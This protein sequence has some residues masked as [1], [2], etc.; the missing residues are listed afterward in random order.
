LLAL[1]EYGAAVK[2]LVLEAL[3]LHVMAPTASIDGWPGLGLF[4]AGLLAI[5]VGIGMIESIM[6]R[7]RLLHVPTLLIAAALSCGFAFLLLSR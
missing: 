1:V 3:L 7:L 6:A 5:A 2:L 4:V